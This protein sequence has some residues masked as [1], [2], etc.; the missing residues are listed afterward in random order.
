MEI[1][2]AEDKPSKINLGGLKFNIF[3]KIICL[4]KAV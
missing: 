4:D 3:C 1:Q 2:E